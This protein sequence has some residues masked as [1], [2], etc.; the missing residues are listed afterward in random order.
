MIAAER[1]KVGLQITDGVPD[2]CASSLAD[3]NI[4][5]ASALAP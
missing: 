4:I 1:E 2:A 5:Q 3:D